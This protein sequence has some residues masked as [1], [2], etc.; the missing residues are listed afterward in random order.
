MVLNVLIIGFL[1]FSN[2]KL[3]SETKGVN[4]QFLDLN[5]EL[6]HLEKRNQELEELFSFSSQG[7]E[8]E[9]LLREKGMYKKEGEEVVVITRDNLAESLAREGAKGDT[10]SLFDKVTN[11]FKQIFERD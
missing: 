8:T 7:E 5:K 2:L 11:F 9:R 10:A 6:E 3:Y 1:V 4:K